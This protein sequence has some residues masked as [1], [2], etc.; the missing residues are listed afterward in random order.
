[1]AGTLSI[2]AD[3]AITG[4]RTGARSLEE[5]QV[6]EA[7]QTTLG[8]GSHDATRDK[9]DT[10]DGVIYSACDRWARMVLKMLV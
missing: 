1:M 4:C 7:G 8:W 5:D 3:M 2:F 6:A 9:K 10:W